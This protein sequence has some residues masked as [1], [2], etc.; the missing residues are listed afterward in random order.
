MLSEIAVFKHLNSKINQLNN[1]IHENWQC[2]NIDES[3]V[4][5]VVFLSRGGES[6]NYKRSLLDKP[7]SKM[8]VMLIREKGHVYQNIQYKF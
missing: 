5:K 3:T 8:Q 6:M 4:I 1:E 2:T 7:M